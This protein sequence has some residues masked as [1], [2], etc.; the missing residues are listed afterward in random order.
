MTA[1]STQGSRFAYK[2]QSA[3]GT[4]ETS[5]LVDFRVEGNPT[6][7][8]P[9]AT[10][11]QPDSNF[12]NENRTEKPIPIF[13]ANDSAFKCKW[14]PRQAS[15]ADGV[16]QT[17]A[18]AESGGLDATL[19]TND[20]TVAVFSSVTA[21][22][23]TDDVFAVGQGC[24]AELTDGRWWPFVVGDYNTGN[25]IVPAMGLPSVTEAGKALNSCLTI[26]PGA[27][28]EIT[29]TDLLTI[30][31]YL[32]S[33]DSTDQVFVINQ[34]CAV[35]SWD[36]IVIEAGQP[37]ILGATFGATSVTQ[38]NG[39]SALSVNSFADYDGGVRL[40][41]DV[42]V[43]FA[44]A[45]AS[46]GITAAYQH[47][48]KATIKLG[49]SAKQIPGF[50]S[51]SCSNGVQGWMKVMSPATITLDMLWDVARMDDFNGTNTSKFISLTRPG[52]AET[53]CCWN[54]TMP[55]AHQSAFKY[56]PFSNAEHRITVTYT[57]NVAGYNSTTATAAL[58]NQP[59][60]LLFGSRG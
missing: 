15:A 50:G 7:A 25:A 2:K 35:T 43:Q 23:A 3:F 28:G 4:A 1:Q 13:Q 27:A 11:V 24:V 6:Q 37:L 12:A 5:G 58:G 51:T 31:T 18:S 52:A 48:I 32:K 38:S 30:H 29:A 47:L 60:Y 41:D 33:L 39:A 10:M 54:F 14:I 42:F 45:S 53:D 57:A 8:S 36:D 59:W 20:T 26:V 44:N 21:F 16:S 40:C 56:E 46:A 55:N 22:T 49:V 17:Q 34:D 9:V 19:S